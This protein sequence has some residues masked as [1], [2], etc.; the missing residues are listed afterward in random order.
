MADEII[1]EYGAKIDKLQAE[2]RKVEQQQLGIEKGA[3]K[4][5]QAITKESEKAAVSVKKVEKNVVGLKDSLGNL[6]SNLPFAH[7]AQ[8][9]A[10]F[11]QAFAGVTQSVTKTTGALNV[12]KIAFAAT[13]IGALI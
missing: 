6:A 5:N 9:A 13:G 10:Q 2:L 11:G 4:S 7:M 12:L 1:V 3:K 8:Q